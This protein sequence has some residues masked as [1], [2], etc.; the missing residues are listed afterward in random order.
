MKT[1]IYIIGII[2]LFFTSSGVAYALHP[3]LEEQLNTQY[4]QSTTKQWHYENNNNALRDIETNLL[5]KLEVNREEQL[6][7]KEGW[8]IEEGKKQMIN[9][10]LKG[11]GK[12]TASL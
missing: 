7:N 3:T 6:D 9:E 5:K 1:K 8:N 11:L 12:E 2:L 10:L 4:E